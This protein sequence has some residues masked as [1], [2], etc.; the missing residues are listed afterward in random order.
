MAQRTCSV[1]GCETKALA[2]GLCNAHYQ[3]AVKRGE[4]VTSRKVTASETLQGLRHLGPEVCWEW[5]GRRNVNGY[6]M[7]W[8]RIDG[9]RRKTGAHR[10]AYEVLVG[11]I[12]DGLVLDHLCRVRSCVNPGH[13]EP[14]TNAENV[15]RP[16]DESGRPLCPQ[17]HVVVGA[18]AAPLSAA[19]H[20]FACRQCKRDQQRQKKMAE[21]MAAGRQPGR[22]GRA[23]TAPCGTGSAYARHKARGEEPCAACVAGHRAYRRELA[24]RKRAS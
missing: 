1:D 11:P 18:N 24:R 4:V 14:V 2:Q 3:R 20:L 19:P 9:T 7:V 10:F 5:P 6:G 12:P 15:R 21:A 23:P 22:I 8:R 17:G 16:R 13:L